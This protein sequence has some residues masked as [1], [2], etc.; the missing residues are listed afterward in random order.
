MYVRYA[1]SL[2]LAHNFTL[3]TMGRFSV[4]TCGTCGKGFTGFMKQGLKCTG[5][6]VGRPLREATIN[7]YY[8]HT[9]ICMCE[10]E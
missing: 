8:V 3:A 2:A 10:E 5:M 7:H 9:Y 4:Y 1:V 6:W